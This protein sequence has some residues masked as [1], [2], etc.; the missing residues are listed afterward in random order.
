M[1]MDESWTGIKL[2]FKAIYIVMGITFIYSITYYYSVIC[3]VKYRP[4]IVL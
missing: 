3:I 2:G 4:L 1:S